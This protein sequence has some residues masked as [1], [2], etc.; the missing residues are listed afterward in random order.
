MAMCD[1]DQLGRIDGAVRVCSQVCGTRKFCFQRQNIV[2]LIEYEG[3]PDDLVAL[4][5]SRFLRSFASI[6]LE[7]ATHVV[8][9][10]LITKHLIASFQGPLCQLVGQGIA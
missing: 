5:I 3:L 9:E 7:P 1:L 10:Q 2:Q 4:K 8:A 6:L